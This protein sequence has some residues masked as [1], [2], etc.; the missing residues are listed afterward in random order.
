MSIRGV[1]YITESSDLKEK[2]CRCCK[3]PH[4]CTILDCYIIRH[5]RERDKEKEI[6]IPKPAEKWKVS[7]IGSVERGRKAGPN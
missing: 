5:G 4:F 7:L 1:Q 6:E 2:M 3:H